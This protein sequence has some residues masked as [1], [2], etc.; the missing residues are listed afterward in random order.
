MISNVVVVLDSDFN[1]ISTVSW[2]K[3]MKL[4][5][6]GKV[7]VVK[8][9]NVIIRDYVIPKIIKLFKSFSFLAGKKMRWSKRGVIERDNFE[10]VYCGK[11]LNKHNATVDHIIPSSKG[12]R[13][14][15][16]NTVAS[17]HKCNVKK[18]DNWLKDTTFTLRF[19]PYEPTIYQQFLNKMKN[20]GFDV[21][22]IF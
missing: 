13:N 3:A 20:A 7:E 11:L 9:S 12:G 5:V 17:C 16:K 2:K 4:I 14:T 6:K 19:Q 18:G 8:Y 21:K 15:W 1:F 10:C 22:E